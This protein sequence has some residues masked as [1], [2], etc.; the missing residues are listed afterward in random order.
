ME[1]R[2]VGR[3]RQGN[4]QTKRETIRDRQGGDSKKTMQTLKNKNYTLKLTVFNS[5]VKPH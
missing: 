4:I 3:E 5:L 1:E 2:D